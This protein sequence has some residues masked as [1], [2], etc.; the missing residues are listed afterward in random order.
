MRLLWNG[1]SK[2][3]WTI[4]RTHRIF[5]LLHTLLW[6]LPEFI[7]VFAICRML[8]IPAAETVKYVGMAV[9]YIGILAG[10]FGGMIWL[11][12]NTGR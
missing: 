7:F 2:Q 11:L 1:L 5:L 9:G 6:T 10:F 8:S 4:D 12:R 3:H